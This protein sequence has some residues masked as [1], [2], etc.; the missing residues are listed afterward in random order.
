MIEIKKFKIRCSA[1]S[2]IMTDSRSKSKAEKIAEVKASIS[3]LQ[4]EHDALKEGLKSKVDKAEKIKKLNSQL[5]ELNNLP[6]VPNLSETCKT[7]L[8][9]WLKEQVYG[10]KYDF[11]SKQT[12]KGNAVEEDAI[13]YANL[14]LWGEFGAKKNTER[15]SD[16]YS[17]GECDVELSESIEDAKASFSS[18]TFPL[19][20]DELPDDGYEYQIQRYMHLWKKKKGGVNYILMPTPEEVLIGLAHQKAR[21]THNPD[22]VDY[23]DKYN[24]IFQR[25][26]DENDRISNPKLTPPKYR[27]KRFEF[28]YDAELNAA[29]NKRVIECREY[30]EKILLPMLKL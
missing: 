12:Y 14:H 4:A 15:K 3:K 16:E 5:N 13:N 18:E 8:K 17:E 30:I 29:I 21:Y 2:K 26:T 24:D 20:E 9:Q 11:T 28:T 10:A 25:L 27:I 22:S 23:Q 1:I 7:Y 19:L 6:D